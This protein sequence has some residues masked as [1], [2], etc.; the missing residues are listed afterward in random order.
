MDSSVYPIVHDRYGI[1]GFE[2]YPQVFET[3]SGPIL[4]IPIA[5]VRFPMNRVMPIGGGAYMRLLP[6]RYTAAVFG[7]SMDKS[8]N[9]RAYTSIRGRSIRTSQD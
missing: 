6:Y 8:I 5:T 4:E 7:A 9:R 1:A 2:R 3:P